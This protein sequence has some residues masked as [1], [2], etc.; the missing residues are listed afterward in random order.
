MYI[1]MDITM[2]THSDDQ[3]LALTFSPFLC[4][5]LLIRLVSSL[6]SDIFHLLVLITFISFFFHHDKIATRNEMGL[7]NM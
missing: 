1:T 4:T 2:E 5:A 6:S 3:S 7:L